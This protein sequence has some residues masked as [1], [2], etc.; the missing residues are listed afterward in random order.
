[1]SMTMS[2]FFDRHP[3]LGLDS[4]NN[5]MIVT[6]AVHAWRVVVSPDPPASG[7]STSEG[8]RQRAE[9]CANASHCP[10]CVHTSW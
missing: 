1:M 9:A 8:L 2:E 6:G 10:V 7:S 3:D 4:K 5:F